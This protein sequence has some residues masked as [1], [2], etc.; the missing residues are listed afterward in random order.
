MSFTH[1]Y[2]P[3]RAIFRTNFALMWDKISLILCEYRINSQNIAWIS[4]Q[5]TKYRVDPKKILLR[6]G[7]D[8]LKTSCLSHLLGLLSLWREGPWS[9]PSPW[10]TG[11]W[12]RGMWSARR[13]RSWAIICISTWRPSNQTHR[14]WLHLELDVPLLS[15]SKGADASPTRFTFVSPQC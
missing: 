7:Q 1:A 2:H 11:Q 8:T 10:S 6:G 5:F 12:Q 14:I 9:R 15:T 4:Y 3:F 13:T